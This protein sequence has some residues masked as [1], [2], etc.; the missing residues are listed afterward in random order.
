M[1]LEPAAISRCH[2]LVVARRPMLLRG[3][4]GVLPWRRLVGCVARAA[5]G[6]HGRVRL[7]CTSVPLHRR[8]A[9]EDD[10][11]GG[12]VERLLVER[13]RRTAREHHVDLLVTVGLL[14]VLL[15]DVV[16]LRSARY[17]R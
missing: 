2:G 12:R 1:L 17:R 6:E 7:L 14:R 5:D 10:R 8:I 3:E 15:D 4:E 11:S 13:E 9:D 16:T